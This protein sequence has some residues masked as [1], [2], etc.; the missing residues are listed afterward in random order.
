M[1]IKELKIE[2]RIEF[3]LLDLRDKLEKDEINTKNVDRIIL[4]I[5]DPGINLMNNRVDGFLK[6]KDMLTTNQK[7]ILLHALMMVH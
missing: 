1:H 2:K 7:K 4:K 5:T 3:G 6:T